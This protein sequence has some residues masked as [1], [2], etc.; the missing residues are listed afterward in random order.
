MRV[1]ALRCVLKGVIGEVLP[2]LHH[3]LIFKQL[4]A[5]ILG[6]STRP[7][8]HDNE[9]HL[10]DVLPPPDQ[11]LLLPPREHAELGADEADLARPPPRHCRCSAERD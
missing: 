9:T 7:A 4:S 5:R 8:A 2:V 1:D 3:G 11:L 10:V 6:Q